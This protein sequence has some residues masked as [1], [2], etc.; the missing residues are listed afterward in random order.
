MLFSPRKR[1]KEHTNERTL[2]TNQHYMIQFRHRKVIK[3]FVKRSTIKAIKSGQ[4]NKK[5]N[6]GK[7]Q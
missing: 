1:T 7:E 6:Y 5:V 2:D 3:G 4:N